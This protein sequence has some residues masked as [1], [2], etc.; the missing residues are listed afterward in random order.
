MS[1][2]GQR[3][4]IT[5]SNEGSDFEEINALSIARTPAMPLVNF[6]FNEYRGSNF[7]GD[8]SG[9]YPTDAALTFPVS[10]YSK[11]TGPRS[12]RSI[13]NGYVYRGTATSLRGQ[14]VFADAATGN[15][16]SVPAS[17]LVEGQN[18]SSARYETRNL[19]FTPDVGQ[20]NQIK[21]FGEDSAGNLYIVDY[22]GDIF[23]IAAG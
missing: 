18:L 4:L 6:G 11:G 1:I 14:Y 9:P 10:Q 16:W 23:L 22:D 12:G 3:L 2:D 17:S 7:T 5:D 8:F 15:I 21:S 19:D 20:I 13:T